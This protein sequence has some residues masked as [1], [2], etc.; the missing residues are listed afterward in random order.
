L[1][2]ER[3]V[4][5]TPSSPIF[6]P[7]GT[8]GTMVDVSWKSSDEIRAVIGATPGGRCTCSSAATI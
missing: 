8:L 2:V 5:S 4:V 1:R 6:D 7:A 3:D